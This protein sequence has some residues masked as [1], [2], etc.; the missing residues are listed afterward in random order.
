MP[1]SRLPNKQGVK[2]LDQPIEVDGPVTNGDPA[3]AIYKPVIVGGEALDFG[4]GVSAQDIVSLW[5]TRGGA[6]VIGANSN[7]DA[8][9]DAILASFVSPTGASAL[10]QTAL[11]VGAYFYDPISQT[12]A[13]IRGN[14]DSGL[15]TM[16]GDPEVSILNL[17]TAAVGANWTA[18]ASYPC[19]MLDVANVTGTDIEYR[20][21]G[22]G[23]AMRIPDGGSR[24]ILGIRDARDIEVRRVDKSNTQVVVTAEGMV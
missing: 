17:T 20:R 24:L 5:L 18:F 1:F 10:Q 9:S 16:P 11:G 21:N 22:T 23:D 2:I 8:G 4:H 13:R 12:W 15:F 14:T 3:P 7:G 19:R 6:A